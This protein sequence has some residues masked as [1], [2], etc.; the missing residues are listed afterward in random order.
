MKSLLFCLFGLLVFQLFAQP[1][2]TGIIHDN[3][4]GSD[5]GLYNP[6]SIVD[7]K[8][9]FA[10]TTDYGSSYV[11]NFFARDYAIYNAD[12]YKGRLIDG[13]K[14]G[15]QNRTLDANILGLKY[16]ID[17]KNAIAYNFRFR[18]FSN[19]R[20]IPEAWNENAANYYYPNQINVAQDITGFSISNLRFTE[21]AFSYAKTIFD[22]GPELLKAGATLK[23]L[24]GLRTN[25]FYANSGTINFT[26]STYPYATIT[27]LDASYG[28]DFGTAQSKYKNRGIGFDLGVTYEIRPDFREQYYE[29]DGKKE[30]VKYDM[31]KYKW[32]FAASITDIGFIKFVKDTATSNF[33]VPTVNVDASQLYD[34]ENNLFFPNGPIQAMALS[35]TKSATQETK[36]RMSMPTMFH[37]SADYH[38]KRNIY[39]NY[40]MSIPLGG[41]KDPTKAKYVFVQTITPRIEKEMY[42][43]MMPISQ[44][45]NGKFY[46]G[47]A[48]RL[49]LYGYSAFIGSNNIL[50]MFGQKSSL[51][52][53]FYIGASYS[54][55]YKTP[56]DKDKD[57]VSD[58]RDL[59]PSDPGLLSLDGCPD[60]DGDGIPDKEDYCIYDQGPLTTRGC[61]DTDGDGIID[62]NDRCPEVKGL[63]VHLGCPDRDYDGVID[64]ADKCPDEPGIELNNGCPFENPGCC[65]DN[66]GDG[67][68]NNVDKCP[69]L[70]GSVYNN[71]C[72]VDK[73]N[74]DKIND[75][76][77]ELDPNHTNSQIKVLSNNDTIRNVLTS[78]DQLNKVM[79]NK[80]VIKELNVYFDS[81]QSNISTTEQEKFDKFMAD[82]K[83]QG[84]SVTFIVVGN[85]D[86]DGSL[87]YNL[88]LSKK[89]AETLMRKIVDAGYLEQKVTVY[90][91]GEEKSLYKGSYS[92][93]Q[94]RMDRKV[95]IK[96][97]KGN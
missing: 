52:R 23:I 19:Q 45:G 39:F 81:D 95:Q 31:N 90:Y 24:N 72:P 25:Y 83:K 40:N 10:I 94:K 60:T 4:V 18:T 78:R 84:V 49:S 33:T 96:V 15:Y 79:E 30:L 89:R 22:K 87:D 80:T 14:N 55:R 12:N 85:T 8:T 7:S 73:N 11:S 28:S 64:V 53:S 88:I 34:V 42:S 26:D 38:Y 75:K 16:E 93:E 61:P 50:F 47:V 2:N 36:F 69:D 54:V 21:H 70:A 41:P 27:N 9:S 97:I 17:H 66:D 71:G 65:M 91:Y 37:A 1:T 48:G 6:S 57:K 82:I 20:G 92:E 77:V 62:M 76:K 51:T 13:K 35:G 56:S 46:V 59:C 3:Y 58:L 29:M 74:I 68:S 32:K 86:R 63:G 67:V 44:M 5:Y 43:V